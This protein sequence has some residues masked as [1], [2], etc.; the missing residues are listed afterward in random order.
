VSGKRRKPSAAAR[1]RPFWPAIGVL[2]VLVVVGL[3][4]AAT[5]PAFDVKRVAVSGNSRVSRQEILAHAAVATHTTI[6]LQNTGAIARRVTA[7]PYIGSAHVQRVPPSTIR[8]QVTE[9]VPYAV[10]QSGYDDA[11]VDRSLRVLE[12]DTT[13]GALPVFDIEPTVTLTPGSFVHSSQAAALRSAFDTISARQI[14][15]VEL[16]FDRYDGL[17]VTL[18]GGLRLLLGGQA[19]LAQK[20]TLAEAILSQIVTRQQR[21]AAIDLRAPSAPVLVYR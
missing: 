5:Y 10:L 15:P 1:T 11:V 13:P 20:L 17:V 4:F 19:D 8:I 21:V 16:G 6:W 18:R 2:A 9:R 7:I 3:G 14:V 12:P